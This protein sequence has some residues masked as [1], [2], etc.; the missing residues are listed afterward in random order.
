M[1]FFWMGGFGGGLITVFVAGATLITEAE[2][3]PERTLRLLERERVTLFRGWP[4]QAT[5]LASHPAFATADLSSLEAR[6]PRRRP[7][8]RAAR[9]AGHSAGPL[10]NDRDVRPLLRRPARP[11]PPAGEIRQPRAHIRRDRSRDRRHGERRAG[12]AGGRSARSSSGARISCG[13]SA[14]APAERPSP[15][16][17]TTAPATRGG[18]TTTGTCTSPD[19]STT[20]SKFTAPTCIRA[21]SKRR[22]RRSPTC[23]A[24]SSSTSGP[25]TRDASARPWSSTRTTPTRQPTSTPT[26]AVALSSFK[27]PA[28]WAIIAAD[29]VP[30]AATGK[31]D[32]D[33]LRRLIESAP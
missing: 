8:G 16:M 26:R 32:Q 14:V 19:V 28:R 21:R 6:Q 13:A 29:D 27:V 4:D 7:P 24:R 11:R 33:G 5:A 3:S 31:V 17:A 30:R 18:S 10:R 12:R 22:S 2:P 25:M 9:P 15:P 20:C 23:A 1:P